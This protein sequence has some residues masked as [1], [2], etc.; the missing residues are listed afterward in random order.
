MD[1]PDHDARSHKSAGARLMVRPPYV[2]APYA[3]VM[4]E[5]GPGLLL[6]YWEILRRHTGTLLLAA[7]FGLLA[8][9]L[10]TL[11]QTPVYRARASLEIQ[12]LNENFLN[13]REVNPTTNESESSPPEYDLQTQVQILQSESVLDRVI[14]KLN[15]AQRFAAERQR[16]RITAWRKVLGVPEPPLES[17]REDL[18]RRVAKNL[19]IQAEPKTRLVEILYNSTD[20]QLAADFSNALTSE[21]IQQN[22]DARWKTTQQ[23]GEWLTSQMEAV[24]IKLEKAEDELQRYATV[25]G[26]LFTSEKDNIAEE[27]LRQLQEELSKAQADRASAQSKYESAAK[28]PPESL[29]EVL[30]DKTLGDYQVKLTDLRRQLAELTSTLTPAHPAVQKVQAQITALESALERERTAVIQRIQNEY[31][32]AQRREGL[33][34]RNYGSQAALVSEQGAKVAHYN[35]LKREVDTNRSLYDSMLRSVQ[36]AGVSNALRASNVRVVDS[37]YPPTRRYRPSYALNLALGLLAGAFFGVAFVVMR[38]RADR[39]IQAPGEIELALGVPEL[40]VIP[41]A[42]AER[43]RYF[44]YYR[45]ARELG[46]GKKEAAPPARSGGNGTLTLGLA[47]SPSASNPKSLAPNPQ[48]P[49]SNPKSPTLN[50]SSLQQV[51]LAAAR[52]TPSVLGESF[53]AALTSILFTGENGDRPRVIVLTSANPGEGKTTVAS[54][55]ALALA[56]S[57]SPVL[58][59]DG[60]LR[61]GRMHEIFQVSNAWG[62]SDVLAGKRL[63]PGRAHAYLETRFPRLFILPAGPTPSSIAG[64]LFSPRTREFLNSTRGAFHTIIIDS[65]PILNMPDAR[66]LSK[67]SDGVVLVIRAAQTT[68]DTAAGAV[69][70]LSADGS[71]VLGTILN[72]WD[73]R[74]AGHAGYGYA[75]PYYR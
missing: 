18:L 21:F 34:A 52:R 25:S 42:G 9:L 37:A 28:A 75:Y 12:N 56:D 31:Q 17:T 62:L 46:E 65:P 14:A 45:S 73:P 15:L 57:G 74:R 70:R 69:Q 38:E 19:T 7:F 1:D 49:T 68:R 54:N 53:R 39:S 63:P 72:G 51:E 2:E 35:I 71:R 64:R 3:E 48:S 29:P 13:M 44:G 55:L 11:P 30:D 8:A 22:L 4:G 5:P 67:L 60:D 43:S 59:I 6:E 58:L 66:M 10:F 32:A 20:P 41:I 26:L 16:S 36:E 47:A 23:T 40:G 61:R 24:R 50:P 27:R 33:L